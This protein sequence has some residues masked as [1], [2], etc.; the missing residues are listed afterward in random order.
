MSIVLYQ[1]APYGLRAFGLQVKK[2]QRLS[3]AYIY[4]SIALMTVLPTLAN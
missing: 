1:T 3:V 4:H 2:L